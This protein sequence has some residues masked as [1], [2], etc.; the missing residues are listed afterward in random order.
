MCRFTK[1]IGLVGGTMG[2]TG[3]AGWIGLAQLAYEARKK[4]E[5]GLK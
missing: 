1:V 3:S 5:R 2:R 4:R